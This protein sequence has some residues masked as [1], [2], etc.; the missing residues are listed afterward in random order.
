MKK[1]FYVRLAL[2]EG[3]GQPEREAFSEIVTRVAS[4]FS[5]RGL[6]DWAVDLP[7]GTKVLGAERE[8][9]DLRSAG[10]AKP[11]MRVYFAT[12]K[13]AG[14]YA[15]L[16]R[17]SFA[18][19]KVGAVRELSPRDW[20][21]TWRKFYHTQVIREAGRDLAVVPAWLKPK[22]NQKV[23]VRIYPGQAFGTGTHPTTRLCLRHFLRFATALEGTEPV[24]VLDF[25][26]GT[27]VLALAA[28]KILRADGRGFQ[29]TAVES[30]PEALKQAGK[31]ARINRAALR[32][33]RGVP[34]RA[35]YDW[36]FANVLAPV[37]LE[38]R[39]TLLGALRPGGYIVLS[40]LLVEE[41]EDFLRR[42][43]RAG[44]RLV[45][46]LSEEGWASLLLRRA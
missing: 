11:E 37:L 30:D 7:P 31:N 32:F 28:E 38:H 18:E 2:P 26:A 41:A 23:Y 15:R 43:H 40:G 17:A 39:A 16:I 25:G 29:G 46:E 5:F 36:I 35:R 21:K 8:F 27:G 42:F 9:H 4:R 13:D 12:K 19:I 33:M 3:L 6:E 1:A 20:M 44:F 24:K 34:V 14:N 10:T 22:K 45:A